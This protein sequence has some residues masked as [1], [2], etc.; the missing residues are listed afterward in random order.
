MLD[1]QAVGSWTELPQGGGADPQLAKAQAVVPMG[2]HYAGGKTARSAVVKQRRLCWLLHLFHVRSGDW[3]RSPEGLLVPDSWKWL[4]FAAM[5]ETIALAEPP[6]G[7]SSEIG[8]PQDGA[9]EV[10]AGAFPL[11][12]EP[13]YLPDDASDKL[14][15]SGTSDTSSSSGSASDATADARDLVGI[16]EDD[17]AVTDAG[18]F[19]QS[20]KVH[21]V[22]ECAES[23]PSPWCRDAPF[24][25]EPVERGVRFTTP[26]SSH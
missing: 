13:G 16:V 3:A 21:A 4:E 18:W 1:L 6:E 2:I 19:C 17:S 12:E 20:K 23:R 9:I 22:R 7:A 15:S 10:A 8:E 24:A 26:A 14:S 25:Q 5:L 11:A